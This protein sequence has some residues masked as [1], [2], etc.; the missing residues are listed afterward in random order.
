MIK[1]IKRHAVKFSK[2]MFIGFFATVLSVFFMWLFVDILK[3]QTVIAATSLTAFFFVWKFYMYKIVNLIEKEFRKYLFIQ[4]LS[5]LLNIY[6]LWLTIDVF[7][8][9]TVLATI[10]V[11]GILFVGR[12]GLFEITGLMKK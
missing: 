5:A 2:F 1:K 7:L 12:Y 4:I 8:I 9:P 10:L 3:I 6:L 11:T